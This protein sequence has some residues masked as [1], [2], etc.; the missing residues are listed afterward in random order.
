MLVLYGPLLSSII[1]FVFMLNITNWVS[2]KEILA[3]LNQEPPRPAAY[4][5]FVKQYWKGA[6]PE[7]GPDEVAE[8]RTRLREW[9]DA[10]DE[11]GAF[12][13]NYLEQAP[14]FDPPAAPIGRG[15]RLPAAISRAESRLIADGLI[16]A[17]LR[18][19]VDGWMA[20]GRER[21]GREYPARRNI[22][23]ASTAAEAA[24]AFMEESSPRLSLA[25]DGGGLQLELAQPDWAHPWAEDFFKAQH[26]EAR[27]L[28]VGI[29]A[30]EWKL[31][32]CK[33]RYPPCGLY[34]VGTKLRSCYKRGTFCKPVHRAHASAE[35]LTRARRLAATTE[36]IDTA[37]RWLSGKRASNWQSDEDLKAELVFVL[38]AQLR[39][40]PT[41]R[42]GRDQIGSK[43]VT[44]NRAA[45]EQRRRQLARRG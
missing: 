34:F 29:L 43:W 9:A 28:F 40:N 26:I 2:V 18:S 24:V 3:V 21:N 20:T 36:L 17:H 13:R 14:S 22:H 35:N 5:Q 12:T 27:R 7:A 31:R 19:L 10:E 8:F 38:C 39:K 25:P 15:W 11:S 32:L 42:T 30:S 16:S 1:V 41:L 37:A 44:R 45:I 6:H 23:R 33:C 4:A